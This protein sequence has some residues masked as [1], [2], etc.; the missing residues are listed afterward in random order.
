MKPTRWFALF[1]REHARSFA[2]VGLG[3][4]VGVLGAHVAERREAEVAAGAVHQA[5]LLE[6]TIEHGVRA[7]MRDGVA[8]VAD[9]YRPR[10][11][12]LFPVLLL[13]TPYDRNSEAPMARKL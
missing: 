4:L 2:L 5:S 9:V 3:V 7:R 13:R 10:S 8:L 11:E 6:A 1:R 12:A